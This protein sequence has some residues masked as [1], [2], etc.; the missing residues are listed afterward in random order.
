M[1]FRSISEVSSRSL[2]LCLAAALALALTALSG[3]G[4]QQ[5]V[6]LPSEGVMVGG[7]IMGG[8]LPVTGATVRLYASA[9]NT[10]ISN[11]VY[12]GAAT[13]LGTTTTGTGGS[14]SFS[15]ASYTCPPNQELYI[16]S[17]GGD[18]GG[19]ANANI[20]EV[21][22]IGQC[23]SLNSFTVVNELTSVASAYAFSSFMS[24][25]TTGALPVVNITA[26]VAN[27]SFASSNN[28]ASGTV[29]TASGLLHAYQNAI[30]LVNMQTGV[31]NVNPVS[32]PAGVI[33]TALLNTLGNVLQACVNSTGGVATDTSTNCGKLFSYTPSLAAVA[34]TNTLQAALNI[35]KNPYISAANVTNLFNLAA[36]Q[37]AFSPTLTT[38]PKDWT[39]AISYPV[40]ANPPTGL[41]FP[42]TVALDANDSVYITSP[43][44]DVY[45]TAPGVPNRS[46]LSA[47]LFGFSSNGALLSTVTPYI[48]TPGSGTPGTSSWYCANTA[49]GITPDLNLL[50]QV[51][52]DAL[53]NIW[54]AN[55][56]A[57]GN[58]NTMVKVNTSS[59]GTATN[60]TTNPTITTGTDTNAP[61]AITVDKED[62]V[63]YAHYSSS[64]TTQSV[65]YFTANGASGP[66][67]APIF[68]PF[69]TQIAQGALWLALDSTQNMWGSGYASTST[70]GYGGT[71][72]L[73][74]YTGTAGNPSYS[75]SWQRKA[76]AGGN[77]STST[78][79]SAPYGVAI[80]SA[81]NAWFTDVPTSSSFPTGLTEALVTAGALQTTPSASTITT[82]GLVAPKWL[83]ADGNNVM[84]IADTGGVVAYSTAATPTVGEISELGGFN[85][86]IPSGTTCTYPDNASTKGIAVDST[87]SVWWT[88]PDVTT[89]N[90][91][92]NR[93]IQ[94]IGTGTATWPLLAT[95]KPGTMPQ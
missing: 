27:A 3:C 39:V 73:L 94:L 2:H 5:A 79:N 40:P 33:P 77:T 28:V 53:G 8:E 82:L 15:P 7:K 9:T 26:P 58:G 68:P 92:S 61:R 16:T 81:G 87:G 59:P 49:S 43:E 83:E 23:G 54:M 18:G 93:L 32:N 14:F 85:P 45:G 63:F 75:G 89:T 44:N 22:M 50:T 48:G 34:P 20:L 84:W 4:L 6:S 38:A 90:A 57:A 35:A 74:P 42:F 80:D 95:G 56:G 64:S 47:C 12:V 65:F 24:I 31:A 21:S 66:Q 41:G 86:C 67:S 37:V 46:S 11:G 10:S 91:N 76:I 29:S 72:L 70:S 88:T 52:P 71:A 30:N 78:S 60:Y 1:A 13:L 51:A 69:V 17:A 25:D 55:L 62:N 19:G 36:P